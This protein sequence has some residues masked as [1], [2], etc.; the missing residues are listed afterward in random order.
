MK[1]RPN[2]AWKANPPVTN[3]AR[4]AEIATRRKGLR[5]AGKMWTTR[6]IA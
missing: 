5:A 1:H 4:L 3:E 6:R 2:G